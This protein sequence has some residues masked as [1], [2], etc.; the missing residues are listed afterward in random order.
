MTLQAEI[1]HALKTNIL[2]VQPSNFENM[3]ITELSVTKDEINSAVKVNSVTADDDMQNFSEKLLQTETE[4]K[5]NISSVVNNSQTD[6]QPDSKG[7]ETCKSN[8][9]DLLTM[10][11]S[12]EN[13]L[14]VQPINF[15]NMA[16]TESLVTENEKN[17]VTADEGIQNFN[18]KPLLT[19]AEKKKNVLSSINNLKTDFQTDLKDN[20]TSKLINIKLATAFDDKTNNNTT[21]STNWT[22]KLRKALN[23][24]KPEKTENNLMKR[25][26]EKKKVSFADPLTVIEPCA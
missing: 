23:K 15:E 1:A 12:K 20:K 25:V 5:K 10:S 24:E 3:T 11:N 22:Q 17:S 16:I 2:Y 9:I 13:N 7:N 26:K 18:E 19:E 8:N 21:S 4:V 14:Y 6:F